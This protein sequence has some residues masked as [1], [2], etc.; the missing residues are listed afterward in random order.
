MFQ[1]ISHRSLFHSLN[2]DHNV[3]NASYVMST[4][5]ICV[6]V[7]SI[8]VIQKGIN[9]NHT[10]NRTREDHLISSSVMDKM[11]KV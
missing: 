1:F 8:C 5:V 11:I 3:S 2:D 4:C 9:S 10:L 6:L 7:F